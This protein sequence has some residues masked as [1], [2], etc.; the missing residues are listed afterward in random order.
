M[1]VFTIRKRYRLATPASVFVALL[2]ALGLLL[3]MSAQ[4]APPDE[5]TKNS[6][7]SLD[8]RVQRLEDIEEIR[9]LL[10]DYGRYLDAHDLAAYSHLFAKDGEWVGGFGSAKGPA[11]IQALME[12]NLGPGPAR[13]PGST[14]HLLTNFVIHVHGDTATAWSRWVFVTTGA[15][16]RPAPAM[17]GHYDDTLVREDGHWKFERRVAVNDIPQSIPTPPSAPK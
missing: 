9:V 13:K 4:A 14:F 11:G 2:L 8:A 5:A 1:N 12:K 7:A 15:E 10:T 17:G 16:N 6:E 3:P